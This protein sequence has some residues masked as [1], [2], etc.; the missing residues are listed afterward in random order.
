MSGDDDELQ[1]LREQTDVGTRIQGGT[2][3]DA[4]DPLTDAIVDKLDAVDD[5]DVSKTLS[6]RDGRLAA[7]IHALEE[8]GDLYDVGVA[9]QEELG[10]EADRDAIDRSE[11][12]RLAVR[13]GLE[14]AAPDTVDAARTA[15][16]EHASRQF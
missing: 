7:L 8:T 16:A 10:R 13:L 5:G 9:L 3:D 15:Q 2:A 12:L 11:A 1:E 14:E 6:L 4:G